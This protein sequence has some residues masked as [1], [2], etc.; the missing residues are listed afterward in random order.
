MLRYIPK[1]DF[2]STGREFLSRGKPEDISWEA[3]GNMERALGGV[4]SG[5]EGEAGGCDGD[6]S[7]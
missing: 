2:F 4:V 3:E 7:F 5:A 1:S 6:S